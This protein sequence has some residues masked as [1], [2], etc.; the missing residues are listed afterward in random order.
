MI[1][2]LCTSVRTRVLQHVFVPAVLILFSFTDAKT[3]NDAMTS[4]N[5]Q[6]TTTWQIDPAHTQV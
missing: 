5:N 2:F 1:F 4:E 6:V 3:S